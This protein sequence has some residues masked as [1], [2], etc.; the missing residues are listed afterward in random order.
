MSSLGFL[1]CLEVFTEVVLLDGLAHV[2]GHNVLQFLD[3]RI[4]RCRAASTAWSRRIHAGAVWIR[5]RRGSVVV[6]EHL[7]NVKQLADLMSNVVDVLARIAKGE[8]KN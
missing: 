7:W 8:L 3:D 4:D 1:A 6:T 2:D 5:R